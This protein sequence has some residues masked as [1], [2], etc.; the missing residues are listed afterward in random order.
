VTVTLTAFLSARIAEDE[1]AARACGGTWRYQ[2]WHGEDRVIDVE[3]QEVIGVF[4]DLDMHAM[5]AARW[6]PA[7]V[8]AECEAKR[9]IIAEINEAQPVWDDLAA[10]YSP[11]G[12]TA[13][14]RMALAK[15]VL[16]ALAQP[17]IDHPDFRPEWR[18]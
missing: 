16:I 6:D 7:R 4:P 17:Y 9:A 5:H 12:W 3:D 1:E 8:L 18:P 15:H 14:A 11:E 10:S 2:L 13:V